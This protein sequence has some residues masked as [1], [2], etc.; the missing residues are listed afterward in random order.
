MQ[1]DRVKDLAQLR[2]WKSSSSRKPLLLRGAR[3]TGKTW[4]AKRFAE[5]DYDD[6]LYI[7][8]MDDPQAGAIFEGSLKPSD[9]L[10]LL[11]AYAHKSVVPGKTLIIFDEV[12]ECPKA[13]TS[14]KFFCED[15]P[16]QHVIATGSHMGVSQHPQSSFPVGKVEMRTLLPLTFVDFLRASGDGVLAERI[17]AA[18][19]S[20]PLDVFESRLKDRLREYMIVGGMPKAVSAF[21]DDR[22]MDEV[23]GIQSGILDAYELDFSKYA[24]QNL[25]DR[26][27]MVWKSIPSQFAK[28][29]RK[30]IYNVVRPGARAAYFESALMWLND[31]GITSKVPCVNA[32][33]FPLRAYEDLS[34]F[35]MYV[36]D[37]GLLGALA[38]LPPSVML[39]ESRLYTEFKGA[40]AE[41]YVC[42]E[43]IAMGYSPTYWANPDGRAEVDFVIQH[44]GRI[45]PIEVKASINRK[46]RSLK[47]A[48]E[49]YLPG[50][51]IRTGLFGF[52]QEDWI[53][54]IPLW[55]FACLPA[56]LERL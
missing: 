6:L 18:D 46:A 24:P 26:I 51:A 55:G 4:L 9:L 3:Q 43:L 40:L 10:P 35:K 42:Q 31:Y 21:L 50:Q 49:K 44:A 5:L 14:L 33:R 54:N 32:M 34:A 52:R 20:G 48:H 29:N 37:V 41:Q 53:T 47:V 30:F 8:F 11:S 17:E 13:L 45:H 56:Y 16:E 1:L 27:R 7:N 15:A 12:R 38:Q 23:R 19:F 2:A 22:N 36:L 28:E 39:D 25:C